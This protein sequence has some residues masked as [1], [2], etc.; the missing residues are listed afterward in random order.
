M[1]VKSNLTK[2]QKFSNLLFSGCASGKSLKNPD[3][4]P[5]TNGIILNPNKIISSHQFVHVWFVL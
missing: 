2:H 4:Y 1:S 3:S 5:F